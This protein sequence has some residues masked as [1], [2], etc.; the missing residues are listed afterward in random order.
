[1]GQLDFMLATAQPTAQAFEPDARI[2]LVPA[3]GHF[4]WMEALTPTL[5]ALRTFL[6]DRAADR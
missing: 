2:E 4:P 6:G 5:T 3:A 1:M